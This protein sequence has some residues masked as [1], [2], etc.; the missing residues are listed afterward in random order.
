MALD[1]SYPG[2]PR[3]W[4]GPRV[5]RV[6]YDAGP[7]AVVGD[8][9][10]RSDL[11]RALLRQLGDVPLLVVGDVC[12]RGP[13][14]R[15]VLDLLVD[16]GAIGTFGNHDVWFAAWAAGEG[17]DRLALGIGG[18]ATLRSYGVSPGDADRRGDAVPE[19]HRSWLLDLAVVIDLTVA[20][21]RFWIVH[22]GLPSDGSFEGASAAEVVPRLA[23][24]RAEDL[25]WRLNDPESMVPV[26][27]PV[28]MG[29]LPRRAPLDAGHVL[30][31]DTGAGKPGGRL[32]AVVLPE[33][34]FVTVGPL[35]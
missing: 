8:V 23:A 22:A 21:D 24:D 10:G 1:L 5:R 29:H 25:L 35:P 16:R 17:F 14:T 31:I 20:G 11:L 30:A 9:H 3:A 26:D 2:L 6:A 27:R 12:D 28:I 32:T 4:R 33:R 7:V 15:G 34:R 18:E 13:D 19:A